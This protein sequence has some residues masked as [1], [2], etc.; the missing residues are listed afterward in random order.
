MG[1]ASD[2]LNAR[3]GQESDT[4]VGIGGFTMFARVRNRYSYTSEVPT[5]YLEDGSSVEDHI[6]LNPITLS[7]EGDVSDVYVS[8]EDAVPP[9]PVVP[10]FAGRIT[11]FLPSRTQS[12]IQKANGI[13]T[14]VRNA[15]SAADEILDAGAQVL[16]LLGSGSSAGKSVQESFIDTM[17]SLHFGRQLVDIEM[18]FRTFKNMRVQCE[19]S[20]DNQSKKI[21]FKIDATEVRIADQA[22]SSIGSLI[23]NPSPEI[24]GQGQEQADKGVQE[25]TSQPSSFL[26]TIRGGG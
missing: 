16:S 11:A 14:D 24:D 5:T 25:G 9:A 8:P 20:T 18:P 12:Q 6:I 7:I 2:F 3:I 10:S 1:K 15:I 17:E 22:L 13:L 21:T 23:V 26:N 4:K 19:I